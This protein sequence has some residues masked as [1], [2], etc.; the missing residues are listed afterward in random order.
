VKN[1]AIIQRVISEKFRESTV[2]TIAHRLSTLKNSNK[3]MVMD[4]GV[5]V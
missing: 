3:I 2:L 5:L 4:K 1:D